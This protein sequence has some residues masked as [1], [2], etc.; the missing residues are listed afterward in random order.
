MPEL[1]PSLPA[2]ESFEVLPASELPPPSSERLPEALVPLPEA[3]VLLPIAPEIPE[4]LLDPLPE[5]ARP[6]PPSS[7]LFPPLLPL[8]V[9]L[10]WPPEVD[11]WPELPPP[12]PP[13]AQMKTAKTANAAA[14]LQGRRRVNRLESSS[15]RV[16]PA[17]MSK[18]LW[19]FISSAP[20]RAK[21]AKVTLL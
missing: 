19:A 10:P 16:L 14:N 6:V 12:P 1:P 7:E 9:P 20:F 17:R 2:E 4:P 11:P 21:R 8:K 13:Q 18:V 5:V 3:P 15:S